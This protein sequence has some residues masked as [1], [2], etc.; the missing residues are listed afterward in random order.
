ML[1]TLASILISYLLCSNC[2]AVT[3]AGNISV[4]TSINE[5]PAIILASGPFKVQLNESIQWLKAS[6]KD[7]S[8]GQLQA[9]SNDKFTHLNKGAVLEGN[10]VYWLRMRVINPFKNTQQ[11]ALSL[12]PK[13]IIIEAAYFKSNGEW[14]YLAQVKNNSVLTAHSPMMLAFEYSSDSY[15]YLRIKAPSTT[16]LDAK[17][18]DMNHYTEDLIFYQQLIGA[19][20]SAVLL[21]I[22]LHFLIL[23][24]H[25]HIHH[26]LMITM[27]IVATLYVSSHAP[28]QHKPEWIFIFNTISPWLVACLLAFFSFDSKKYNQNLLSNK[29]FYTV[30]ILILITLILNTMSYSTLLA[31]SLLPLAFA[32]YNAIKTS[33]IMFM[34]CLLFFISIAWQLI[35]IANPNNISPPMNMIEVYSM[36]LTIT[37]ASLSLITPYFQHNISNDNTDNI[38]NHSSFLAK[39]SHSFRT[40]MNGVLGMSELLKDTPL[41]QQ[42]RNYLS[43]IEQSGNDLLR[44]INRVSDIGKIQTGKLQFNT[45]EFDLTLAIEKII[46]THIPLA[47]QNHVEII[48]NIDAKIPVKIICDE[49]RL[50]TVIDN[51]LLNALSHT[52]NGEIEIR[53]HWVNMASQDKLLFTI[54]DSG[55]GISEDTLKLVLSNHNP[56]NNSTMDIENIDFGL[57]LSKNI[58][59]ALQ[60]EFYI[61]SSVSIGT[62]IR[63]SMTATPSGNTLAKILPNTLSGLS[64]LIVDDNRTFRS[65]IQQYAQTWGAHADTTYNGKEALALLRNHNNTDSPYDIIIIDQ[66][67]PIMDGFELASKIKN[68]PEINQN[69][70]KI[71][72]TGSGISNKNNSV[73][74]T[75]IHQVIAKPVTSRALQAV[76]I[77][78]IAQRSLQIA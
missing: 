14:S 65:V 1:R 78:H 23:Q 5:P 25:N 10:Q 26:Y 52:K 19:S 68:D 60:E 77:E 57:L 36:V 46:D 49:D 22:I 64:I 50:H 29:N 7:L 30:L 13:N 12:A 40:P 16:K 39:L 4:S 27:S 72:L 6:Y 8:L 59:E 28:S 61:E 35:Y 53:A 21:I 41:S 44:L 18:K 31:A 67:M 75:G 54:R 17:L 71:M 38:N 37:L 3:A 70:I 33:K 73:I 66:E 62:S 11:L 63:F 56:T 55:Q 34:A 15:I 24:S 47:E 45:Q 74:D 58:I 20:L 51:L 48:V 2:L 32:G 43:T 76:L 42:Q 69:I 9:S